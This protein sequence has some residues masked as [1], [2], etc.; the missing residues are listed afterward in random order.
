M[1]KTAIRYWIAFFIPHLLLYLCMTGD[2]YHIY[3]ALS[4]SC[5]LPLSPCVKF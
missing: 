1:Q 3:Q 4:M 5:P 2:L